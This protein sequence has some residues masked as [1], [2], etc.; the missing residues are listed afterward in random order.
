MPQKSSKKQDAPK[1]EKSQTNDKKF[2]VVGIGASAGGLE[3]LEQFFRNMPDDTGMAFIVVTHQE[4][5]HHSM[6][7]DLLQKYTDMRV[8][9]AEDKMKVQPNQVY[10]AIPDNDLG[11]MN[12][13]I[14]LIESVSDGPKSPINYFLLSLAQDVSEYAIAILLSGMGSDGSFGIKDVKAE[15]G[16][17]MAQSPESAKYSAMLESAIKTGLV[18]YILPPEQ[19][20]EQ[21]IT[22]TT[23]LRKR[24]QLKRDT[25]LEESDYLHKIF[26]LL[27]ANTGHDFSAYKR[28]TIVRRVER[29]MNVHQLEKM[30]DYVR[31]LQKNKHEN[32]ILF[33]E[34]LISVTSFFRDQEAFAA[35]EKKGLPVIL[36]H[37]NDDNTVRIWVPGCSTGEEVYSVAMLVHEY[38]EKHHTFSPVQIFG[39]DINEDNIEFARHGIYPAS[40]QKDV[41]KKR[42]DRFFIKKDQSYQIQNNIREMIVFAPHNIIKDPPFTRLDLICCRNLLIYLD[43]NLQKKLI[44]LFHYVLEKNGL[45]FLGSSESIGDFRDLFDAVD[46]KVKIYKRRDSAVAMQR[47]PDLNFTGQIKTELEKPTPK[48]PEKLPSQI[49]RTL[50][51]LFAPVSVVINAKGEIFYVHGRTGQFLEAAQGEANWNIFDMARDGLRL[52]LPA[53]VRKAIK[54][55]EPVTEEHLKVKVN[56]KYIYTTIIVHPLQNNELMKEFLIV[57]F[58]KVRTE[59]QEDSHKNDKPLSKHDESRLEGLEKELQYTKENLQTTIE[60]LETSN[61]ELKSINEEYQS[62]NEELHSANE[63]LETSREEMHSLNEELQTVNAELQQKVDEARAAYDDIKNFID[64]LGIPTLL[65]DNQ[66]RVRQFSE[67]ITKII[68]LI[69]SDIGRAI[70]DIVN[71]LKNVDLFELAHKV[72]KSAQALR[73]E[74]QTMDGHWYLLRILPFRTTQD[75]LDGVVVSFLDIHELMQVKDDYKESD[76]RFRYAASIVE[77]VREPLVVLDKD[78]AVLSA[79]RAFYHTFKVSEDE[80]VGSY[81]YELSD[82]QWNIPELITFLKDVIPKQESFEDFQVEH[83]F[84]RIGFRKM[85]LN[86]RRIYEPGAYKERILLAIEDVT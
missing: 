63:E 64:C 19:M 70:I 78:L 39:T 43:A 44:P 22:Y 14:Q 67:D 42:L 71:N 34:L 75:R 16:M 10:V 69:P 65:L 41:G 54:S 33:K 82:G 50:V 79:N 29:R 26:M 83:E 4:S 52:R 32:Q 74:V 35:L 21:L 24:K 53:A 31:Y 47:L 59:E 60:E 48:R 51:Q 58:H 86:A 6:L 61:E 11:L 84:P 66:M 57:S 37:K 3:A 12:R 5:G 38:M 72:Q 46:T 23:Q 68:R 20:P 27:R 77:T 56:G 13:S 40:I 55:G 8:N 28:N 76:A 49:E 1:E 62:T 36:D 2:P 7:P 45:L 17:V 25:E 18:D 80:T 15:M 85:L 9:R 81:L 73:K 30:S